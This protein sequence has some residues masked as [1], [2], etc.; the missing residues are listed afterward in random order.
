MFHTSEVPQ[1]GKLFHA[2]RA[3][4]SPR[5]ASTKVTAFVSSSLTRIDSSFTRDP[6]LQA[7]LSFCARNVSFPGYWGWGFCILIPAIKARVLCACG[8]E[9]SAIS[10][11]ISDVCSLELQCVP[12]DRHA[13][14]Y[15]LNSFF[16][17]CLL[18]VSPISAQPVRHTG[19]H[20]LHQHHHHHRHRSWYGL[21]HAIA[22]FQKPVE[23]MDRET[24]LASKPGLSDEPHSLINQPSYESSKADGADF[25]SNDT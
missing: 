5:W 13:T 9:C 19:L 25:S 12:Q 18:A 16:F 23:R 17:V 11:L 3:S 15:L 1:V 24:S 2:R 4:K 7:M 14:M 6:D 20:S 10:I 21:V 22:Q 8:H